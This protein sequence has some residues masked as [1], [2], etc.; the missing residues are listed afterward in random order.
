MAAKSFAQTKFYKYWKTYPFLINARNFMNF[1]DMAH[2]QNSF[3]RPTSL[4]VREHSDVFAA[5]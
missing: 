1:G 4:N 5:K 2:G 3:H